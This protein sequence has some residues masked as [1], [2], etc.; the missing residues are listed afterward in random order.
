MHCS[1]L[2][3]SSS[4]NVAW[5]TVPARRTQKSLSFPIFKRKQ[6]RHEPYPSLPPPP[7]LGTS[8]LPLSKTDTLSV[9]F[10]SG[11]KTHLFSMV[12]SPPQLPHHQ[13][14]LSLFS[15]FPPFVCYSQLWHCPLISYPATNVGT[16]THI[17]KHAPLYL[18]VSSFYLYFS[19]LVFC[20]TVPEPSEI[21]LEALSSLYNFQTLFDYDIV[22]SGQVLFS[23]HTLL[24]KS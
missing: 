14:F 17:H 2:L 15:L 3:S 6:L 12:F 1:R 24:T 18:L 9:F 11:V 4:T 5:A 20:G 13:L 21:T 22:C 16:D 7:P 8:F 10:L 19:H 23:Q